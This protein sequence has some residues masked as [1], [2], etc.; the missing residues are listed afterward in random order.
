MK[1]F[2]TYRRSDIELAGAGTGACPYGCCFDD[3]IRLGR[4]SAGTAIDRTTIRIRISEVR[5]HRMSA[6]ALPR[7]VFFEQGL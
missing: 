5:G 7:G 1:I 6:T 3:R 2:E 4:P